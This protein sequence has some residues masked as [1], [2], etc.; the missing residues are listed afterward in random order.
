MIPRCK[1]SKLS[2]TWVNTLLSQTGLVSSFF[3]FQGSIEIMTP[4]GKQKTN[5][6]GFKETL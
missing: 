6:K 5:E 1:K 2:L 4:T 3:V